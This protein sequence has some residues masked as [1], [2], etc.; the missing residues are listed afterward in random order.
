MQ[1]FQCKE[2]TEVMAAAAGRWFKFAASYDTIVVLE[3]KELPEHVMQCPS[4]E[5]PVMMKKLMQ[6]LEDAGEA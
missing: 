5:R 1:M 4:V 3:R 2:A 6:Q